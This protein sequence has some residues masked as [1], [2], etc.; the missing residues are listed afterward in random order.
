MWG[1]TMSSCFHLPECKNSTKMIPA[2]WD[3]IALFFIVLLAGCGPKIIGYGVI[4]WAEKD[5]ALLNGDIVKISAES[6]IQKSYIVHKDDE[7]KGIP[8]I[9]WRAEFFTTYQDAEDFAKKFRPYAHL[10]AYSDKDG[11][12]PVREI[13]LNSK[14]VKI[15]SKPKAYQVMKVI[16]RTE[17]KTK[18][19]NMEDYW[20]YVLIEYQGIGKSGNYELLGEKGYC[21]GYYLSL[22]N[23]ED[24]PEKVI[25]AERSVTNEDEQLDILLGSTWRPSY[26]LDMIHAGRIDLQRFN[27]DIGLFPEPRVNR[28]TIETLEGL[29][30]FDY[31]GITHVRSSLFSFNDAD[32]RI[33]VLSDSK[34]SVTYNASGNQVN[35]IF[36]KIK[37]DINELCEREITLRKAFY[38]DFY[39]RGKVLSSS[40]YGVIN[41]DEKQYF[42]WKGCEK[43]VPSIIPPTAR[44]NGKVDFP[45][46]IS[47]ELKDRYDGVI[48]LYF[49][50]YTS[51]KG[52]NFLYKFT[53]Q[54]VRLVSVQEDYIV[55]REVTRTGINPII[56]FFTFSE[57]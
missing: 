47:R 57:R 45:F 4:L 44:K 46:Y 36:V 30:V 31:S 18:I 40:A 42:S 9:T 15:I 48:T 19:Q 55:D 16:G 14:T 3:F 17:E 49:E 8:I 20:Y 43:L 52:I 33:E 39:I 50:G 6:R 41:L 5:T 12:P 54:G 25:E 56:I 51:E 29:Y 37:T 28:I 32:L 34:I 22:I 24:E 23:T 38:N 21:F 7:K 10:Y 1:S 11:I 27:S 35:E 53:E 2:L 13:P 26:F